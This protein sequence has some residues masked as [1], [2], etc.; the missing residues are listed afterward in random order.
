ML[1]CA[2]EAAI[3][4]A[5]TIAAPVLEHQS[6]WALWFGVL[7]IAAVVA[8]VSYVRGRFDALYRELATGGA[9]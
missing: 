1:L 3:D 7:A 4:A 9:H 2:G 6:L 8:N 5:I